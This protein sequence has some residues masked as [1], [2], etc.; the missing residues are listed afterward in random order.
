MTRSFYE[1]EEAAGL[2]GLSV[3][4]LEEMADL[5]ELSLVTLGTSRRLVRVRD[6]DA[7]L[8]RV[9]AGG[10]LRTRREFR[11]KSVE[12]ALLR[13]AGAL[14]VAPERLRYKVADRGSPWV[15][16][17][18]AREARVVVDL[19]EGAEEDG[20]DGESASPAPAG[21]PR[22]PEPPREE[23]APREQPAAADGGTRDAGHYYAPEQV[24]WLLGEDAYAVNLRIY[25][26]ELATVDI[27]GYRWVPK[28]A[29][30]GLMRK[31]PVPRLEDPPR[32][33]VIVRPPEGAEASAGG[34]LTGQRELKR[35]DVPAPAEH[36]KE[37]IAELEEHVRSLQRE[38]RLEK[39][40]RAQRLEGELAGEDGDG[41]R[42]GD[43][44][45][46]GPLLSP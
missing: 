6:V 8:E 40:R 36:L 25:R 35:E 23:A 15:V 44:T 43:E 27:N 42:R 31:L 39:A 45:L 33:F 18:R 4:E 32:P 3:G 17:L 11:G 2:L 9:A 14:G 1:L 37:R 22:P 46:D 5:G 16:G 41:R 19:P 21:E 29:V 7:A 20:R 26:K 34:S 30:E 28:E 13:A 10:R 38:L 24:A 12:D